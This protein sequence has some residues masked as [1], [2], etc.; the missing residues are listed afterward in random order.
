MTL[1][2]ADPSTSLGDP[3]TWI[4]F[5][6]LGL[7]VAGLLTGWIWSKPS[8]ERMV[9]ER[10]RLLLERDRANAQ[11]DAMAEVLQD[12][13]LPVVTEFITTTRALLP[14]LQEVQ[15]LQHVVPMLQDFINK[16]GGDERT[17]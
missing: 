12:R 15:R 16:A 7:L 5:G 17:K 13:L 14:V 8:A 4:N 2:A 3:L 11:R 6:V 1:A 10:D 9:A